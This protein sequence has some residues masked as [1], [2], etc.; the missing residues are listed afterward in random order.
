MHVSA[1]AASGND[2]APAASMTVIS[3]AC[4]VVRPSS[5]NL[6]SI[7]ARNRAATCRVVRNARTA[8]SDSSD[9][10]QVRDQ[11]AFDTTREGLRAAG[12]ALRGRRRRT[13]GAAG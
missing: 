8:S 13:G 1:S 10:D 6:R 2:G 3:A 11:E 7:A 9:T 5:R 4:W 12:L